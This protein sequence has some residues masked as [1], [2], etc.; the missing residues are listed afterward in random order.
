MNSAIIRRLKRFV[1]RHTGML[2]IFESMERQ[3]Q[4]MERQQ[5]TLAGL[6]EA[7]GHQR[8]VLADLNRQLQSALTRQDG[9]QAFGG[10]PLPV[11][12]DESLR[13]MAAP[14]FGASRHKAVVCSIPKSGTYL[15]GKLLELLGL[16][17]SM[18][19][20]W[21]EGLSDYR[22]RTLD[23]MRLD[24]LQFNVQIPLADSLQL[25]RQG[26]FAVG[27]LACDETN[28]EL[29]KPF[30]KIFVYRNLRDALV[31]WMR[32]HVDAGRTSNLGEF[33]KSIADGP[34]RMLAFLDMLGERFFSTCD[35]RWLGMPEVFSVSFEQ[36]YGDHG[37]DV[38]HESI[39][40]L[41]RFLEIPTPLVDPAKIVE[42]LI[43][44]PTLTWSGSRTRRELY[45]ND[46]VEQRFRELGGCHMNA[47][48]GYPE[49]TA[50]PH[51]LRLRAA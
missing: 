31:S 35:T 9:L 23:Q 43:G 18:L 24:Y 36:L 17:P 40:D 48:L 2:R 16:V 12:L 50:M 49:Q 8:N 38:Q 47:K 10:L 3:Q 29:L 11:Y 19:H 41:H 5:Q 14:Q 6:S 20:V 13:P 37:I 7:I 22:G 26:Q 15:V 44:H 45:W 46:A 30:R 28:R 1:S 51:S 25:I 39:R 42:D 21:P 32:F 33:W 27:H 34:D 4:T